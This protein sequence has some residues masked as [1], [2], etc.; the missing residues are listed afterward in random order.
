MLFVLDRCRCHVGE[1]L[2][3]LDIKHLFFGPTRVSKGYV[4]SFD[5]YEISLDELVQTM[6]FDGDAFVTK[7]AAFYV[8]A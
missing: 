8:M 6:T 1:T 3:G 2:N 7:V 4:C 5:H